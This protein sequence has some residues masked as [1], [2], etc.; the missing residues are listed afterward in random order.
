MRIG[1]WGAPGS[2]KTTFMAALNVA[3]SRAQQD[4]LMYGVDEESTEFLVRNTAILTNQ[5]RFPATT[6]SLHPLCWT[7]NMAAPVPVRRRFGGQA[8]QPVPLQLNIDLLDVPGGIFGSAPGAAPVARSEH[9]FGEEE[10]NGDD[11]VASAAEDDPIGRL[12]ACDG[13]VFLFDPLREQKKGDAYEYFQGTLL[14]IA[15]RCFAQSR[16]TQSRMS[17]GKLPHCVAVC[18]TKFDDPEIYRRARMGGWQSYDENDP[19]LFPRVHNDDAA[20]FFADLCLQS[21]LSNA[22]LI[23]SAIS[24]YFEPDRVRYFIT[25]AIG[26]Y[27]SSGARRFLEQDYQNVAP[28]GRIRGAVHPINVVEPLLWLGQS[29]ATRTR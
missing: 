18:V 13:I 20:A 27:V 4:L 17:V 22:D 26:F 5:R 11:V 16:T 25:S 6:Q 1:L 23:S 12:A 9:A 8:K 10:G 2:G 3:V 7:M 24:R 21:D 28:D 15:Q 19:F 14:R 29:L